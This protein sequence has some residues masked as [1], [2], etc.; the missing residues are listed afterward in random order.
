VAHDRRDPVELLVGAPHLA[1]ALP[2]FGHLPDHEQTALDGAP[3]VSGVPSTSVADRTSDVASDEGHRRQAT[4][5]TG[6]TAARETVSS[7]RWTFVGLIGGTPYAPPNGV[8]RAVIPKRAIYP[9]VDSR[10]SHA[11][12]ESGVRP[13]V[14]L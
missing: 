14:P 12:A 11:N 7:T 3:V 2:A 8:H 10:T 6:T 13:T 5:P 9:P 4:T 1:L